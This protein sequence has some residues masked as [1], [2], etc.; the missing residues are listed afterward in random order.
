MIDGALLFARSLCSRVIPF[1]VTGYVSAL[2]R[3]HA[4]AQYFAC[5][6]TVTVKIRTLES[7]LPVLFAG[8]LVCWDSP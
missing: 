1:A 3:T 5:Y 2:P 7:I 6:L 8:S 4:R